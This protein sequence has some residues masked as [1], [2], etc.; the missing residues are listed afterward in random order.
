M[1]VAGGSEVVTQVVVQHQTSS[2]LIEG[3]LGGCVTVDDLYEL[4][5]LVKWNAGFSS[6]CW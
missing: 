4:S 6:G 1:V 3:A 5:K 2:A